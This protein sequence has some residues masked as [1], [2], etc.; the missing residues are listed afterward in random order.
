MHVTLRTKAN[1]PSL[2]DGRLV[3]EFRRSLA[4]ACERGPRLPETA[5]VPDARPSTWLLRV[6]SRLNGGV[7]TR[8]DATARAL[9]SF[10]ARRCA[11]SNFRS[12]HHG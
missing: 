10:G 4:E 1:L 6:G 5:A 12:P 7:P 11:Y 8:L 9:G 3:H 2:R